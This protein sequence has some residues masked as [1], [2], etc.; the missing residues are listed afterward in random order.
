MAY[1]S[2]TLTKFKNK[3]YESEMTDENELRD[4][5]TIAKSMP[6]IRPERERGLERKSMMKEE[7]HRT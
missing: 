6:Y 1:Y 2:K 5:N 3:W 4:E 7:G